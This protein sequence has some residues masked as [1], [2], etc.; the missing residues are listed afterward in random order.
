VDPRKVMCVWAVPRLE[1]WTQLSWTVALPPLG[2]VVV[3]MCHTLYEP[4]AKVNVDLS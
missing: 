2:V 3:V 4:R 1:S